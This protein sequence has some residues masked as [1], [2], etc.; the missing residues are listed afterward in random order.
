MI[1]NKNNEIHEPFYEI[2]YDAREGTGSLI[3]D[4]KKWEEYN[5]IKEEHE[6]ILS[7]FIDKKVHPKARKKLYQLIENVSNSMDD[8]ED[9]ENQ[10]YYY[11]GIKD[12]LELFFYLFA[13]ELNLK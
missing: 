8:R 11:C 6:K 4:N 3:T 13:K 1:K 5:N 9:F 10:Q 2:I 12:A 7:E